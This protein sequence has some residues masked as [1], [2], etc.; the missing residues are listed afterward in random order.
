MLFVTELQTSIFES[1]EINRTTSSHK[2]YHLTHQ[3]K[4]PIETRKTSL[5]M[6]YLSSTICSCP[7]L[8]L[9]ALGLMEKMQLSCTRIW[10]SSVPSNSAFSAQS[11]RSICWSLG[12]RKALGEG[13]KTEGAKEPLGQTRG[14]SSEP[15]LGC[16]E[17]SSIPSPSSPPSGKL[18]HERLSKH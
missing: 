15:Q 6:M 11:S 5:I 9:P 14:R 7:G 10:C 18:S 2:S 12:K 3:I 13:C 8:R 17:A 1:W 4:V 16:M